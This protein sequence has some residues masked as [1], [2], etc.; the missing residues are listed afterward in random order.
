MGRSPS[1]SMAKLSYCNTLCPSAGSLLDTAFK[2]ISLGVVVLI[3]LHQLRAASLLYFIFPFPNLIWNY[4]DLL[5]Q[6]RC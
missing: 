6:R 1:G 4:S 2:S 5:H 3:F